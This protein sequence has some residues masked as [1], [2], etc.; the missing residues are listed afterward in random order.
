MSKR[1][2][3]LSEI[4]AISREASNRTRTDEPLSPCVS[5]KRNLIIL[6]L[7]YGVV[8]GQDRSIVEQLAPALPAH[9][10]K[11]LTLP[12]SHSR[13]AV[14]SIREG[15]VY[16]F[17]KRMGKDYLCEGT[18]RVHDS[19]LLQ[20]VLSYEPG[21]PLGGVSALG[22]WTLSVADPEDVDEARLLFTPDPLSPDMLD[23]YLKVNRYRDLLQKFDLR[24][25]ANSC[26]VFDDVITPSQVDS[27]VAEFL[28]TQDAA[29]RTLLE[30]QA[31]PPF[32]S[33]LAPGEAPRDMDSI[34]RNAL[35]RMVDAGGVALVLDDPIGI[36]QELNAWRNDAVEINLPW[37]KTVDAQG[38]SNERKYVVAE[39][40]DDVKA[41][42]QQGY[43]ENAVEAAERKVSYEKT[44][45]MMNASRFGT[46]VGSPAEK[47]EHHDPERVLAQ[48]ES[49][50]AAAF[51]KYEAM[52]DWDAKMDIQEQ[53]ARRDRLAQDEM[54]KRGVDHLAW[55]DSEMLEQ[56]LDFYDRDQPLWGQ[57][58]ASQIALC[59]LGMNGSRGGEAKLASW[60]A[61]TEI[62]KRNL[63]WRA[64]TR[65]Q[66]DIEKETREAFTKAKAAANDLTADTI[67]AEL[68]AAGGWFQKVVDLLI[69]ADAAVQSAV[70]S[71]AH[72][73]FDPQRLAVTLVPFAWLHQYLLKLLPANA[74]DRRLLS[75][76]LGFVYAGL[77]EVTTRLRMSELA[78]S[79][80]TANPNRVAGQVNAHIGR[81]RDTLMR[82]FQ[83]GGGGGFHQLR[84]GVLLALLE[85]IILG[86]KASTKN[87]GEKEYLEFQA[88]F[89]ITTAAGIELAAS[90]V[91]MVAN[92]YATG[93]VSQGARVSLGG[94]RLVGG[95][96][97]T[98]GGVML[99]VI[100]LKDGKKAFDNE[101]R[102]LGGAYFARGILSLGMS[103][104]AGMVAISFAGPL[105][106][107][108]FGQN[109]QLGF[110][111]VIEGLAG[112]GLPS[113]MLKIIGVGSLVT[114]G[115][116]VAIIYLSPSKIEEWCWHSCLKK[117]ESDSLLKPFKDQ[118]TELQKLYEA[119]K[120]VS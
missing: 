77:G 7:R 81:V 15:Y 26:G 80:Q 28:A 49:G 53:F 52:L 43:V 113:V 93:V 68:G 74:V 37:L 33:A 91:Q 111:A 110:I 40:L 59:L 82:E 94:L 102:I 58:F 17:V 18:Y 10:G 103:L 31:F 47:G 1:T 54:D 51:D 16:V 84:G 101:Y 11:R 105:L 6:P 76:M 44:Y 104:L 69:K 45:D 70:V 86:V 3:S 19:G 8:S 39:A 83:N 55:L 34:Y 98:V 61:G 60:W 57:A 117:W 116:S 46:R 97:A 38:I 85:G 106:R 71:D 50:K 112:S 89:L 67:V 12:L 35:D 27:I 2:Y 120:E 107:F 63:V 78:A 56:A 21:T 42:M 48:A 23:R 100:D 72:R 14:R 95:S 118:E 75:P 114:L 79:G 29:A 36:V 4:L 41:A 30:K 88:A 119:L 64:L 22:G 62:T 65:N 87:E 109:S 9:L 32:R 25:L 115:I 66:V 99:A 13:Y 90:G 108:I 20:P 92:R 24:T 5:C 96:L 73:W